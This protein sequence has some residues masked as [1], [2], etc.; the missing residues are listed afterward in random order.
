MGKNAQ[1]IFRRSLFNQPIVFC[2][3]L[4]LRCFHH[5]H[6]VVLSFNWIQNFVPGFHQLHCHFRRNRN[7]IENR[8][9]RSIYL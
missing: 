2:K 5:Q 7:F 6:W 9:L 1:N 3:T 4:N 8:W